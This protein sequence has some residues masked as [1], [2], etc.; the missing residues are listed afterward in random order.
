MLIFQIIFFQLCLVLNIF[1]KGKYEVV[2]IWDKYP[3]FM[4]LSF[5]LFFIV[6]VVRKHVV[7]II[8]IMLEFNSYKWR[9]H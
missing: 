7:K 4:S 9:E 6:P 5:L 3:S 2:I 8:I 1:K